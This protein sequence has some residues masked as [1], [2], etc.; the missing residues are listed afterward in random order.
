MGRGGGRHQRT[1]FG[2]HMHTQTQ[3]GG[4][5]GGRSDGSH[6][7]MAPGRGA[8]A[9]PAPHAYQSNLVKNYANWNVCYS[10]GFDIEDRHTSMTC[11]TSWHRPNHPEGFTWANAQEYINQGW[12]PCTKAMHKQNSWDFDKVGWRTL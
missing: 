12:D 9:P 2:N 11:P 1:P 8:L 4:R 5:G 7:P 10:C 6:V 3:Q